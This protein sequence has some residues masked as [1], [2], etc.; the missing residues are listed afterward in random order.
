L[1]EKVPRAQEMPSVDLFAADPARRYFESVADVCERPRQALL[2]NRFGDPALL[3]ESDESVLPRQTRQQLHTAELF[4]GSCG[5]KEPKTLSE[6][7]QDTL[8]DIFFA[9]KKILATLPK[10]AKQRSPLI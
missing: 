2:P 8:K 10:M 3:R 9:E 4:R 6:L 5:A 1:V 7:F